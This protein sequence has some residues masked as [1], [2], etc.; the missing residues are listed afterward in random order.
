MARLAAAPSQLPPIVLVPCL[1]FHRVWAELTMKQWHPEGKIA[2][3]EKHSDESSQ[4]LDPRYL[5]DDLLLISCPCQVHQPTYR[6][7]LRLEAILMIVHV[8]L[9][10]K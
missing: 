6:L 5:S 8:G 10:H 3:L 1:C 9:M 4:I 2:H 7:G